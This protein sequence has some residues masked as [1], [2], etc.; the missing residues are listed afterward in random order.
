MAVSSL[1][2]HISQIAPSVSPLLKRCKFGCHCPVKMILTTISKIVS[3]TKFR[4]SDCIL[5]FSILLHS[6][7]TEYLFFCPSM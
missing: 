6:F 4:S 3:G 7:S 2:R 1:S 5:Y